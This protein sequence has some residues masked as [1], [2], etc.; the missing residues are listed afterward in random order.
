[1]ALFPTEGRGLCVA[2]SQNILALRGERASREVLQTPCERRG[3]SLFWLMQLAKEVRLQIEEASTSYIVNKLLLPQLRQAHVKSICLWD[4]VPH[5]HTGIPSYYIVH[6]WQADFLTMVQILTDWFLPPPK[7]NCPP[8]PF[9]DPKAIFMWID[10]VSFPQAVS[11]RNM[12]PVDIGIV[13]T[14]ITEC[15]L[16]TLFVVDERAGLMSRAWCIFEV[17]LTAYHCDMSKLQVIFPSELDLHLAW[18]LLTCVNSAEITHAETCKPDDKLRLVGEAKRTVGLKRMHVLMKEGL[19]RAIRSTLRWGGLPELSAY[20]A[21][22]L[23]GE[24]YSLLHCTLLS[25]PELAVDEQQLQEIRDIFNMYDEDGSGELDKEEF[26]TVLGVA[27]F[28]AAEAA[29]I[30]DQV[31]T[32]GGDGVS[33]VE[34]EQ[35]W[36]ESQR[37]A[38]Q[39]TFSKQSDLS[40]EVLLKTM[41]NFL[42]LLARNE[43][44]KHV[45]FFKEYLDRMKGGELFPLTGSLSPPPLHGDWKEIV[46]VLAW[47]LHVEDLDGCSKLL[48]EFL[49]CN[50]DALDSNIAS[51]PSHTDVLAMESKSDKFK[52]VQKYLELL[53]GLLRWHKSRAQQAKVFAAAADKYRL[54]SS[55]VD[56]IRIASPEKGGSMKQPKS[57]FNFGLVK[58]MVHLK[59]G[60]NEAINMDLI[61]EASCALGRF[62][63]ANRNTKTSRYLQHEHLSSLSRDYLSSMSPTAIRAAASADLQREIG[64]GAA[65]SSDNKEAYEDNRQLGASRF[66]EPGQ[67]HKAGS[68]IASS[69]FKD[70][71]GGYPSGKSKLCSTSI[72]IRL[73]VIGL[74]R[75]SVADLALTWGNSKLQ[76]FIFQ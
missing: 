10:F 34:F 21:M 52:A 17:F 73:P 70:G 56:E 14:V 33:I 46:D 66:S 60:P 5:Q 26:V 27:G 51:L 30:F 58:E 76:G 62:M 71:S 49:M 16:G 20:C 3:I 28:E 68:E 69:G 41:D 39:A 72:N 8:V 23:Q 32:D 35:W 45:P 43:Q 12:E 1:M 18:R 29:D 61:D 40:V 2:L 55:Y 63:A 11:P 25:L 6:A 64:D 54:K 13:R 65:S 38:W 15:N 31:N 44:E 22:L 57:W 7:V 36:V 50:A 74:P 53:V 24:E 67:R 4:L 42:L 75:L 47:K 19:R 59:Y 9:R 48:F 37:S